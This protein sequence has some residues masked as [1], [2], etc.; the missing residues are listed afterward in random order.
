VVSISATANPGFRFSGWSG[1]LSGSTNPTSVV[2]N[3][4]KNVTANFS[5]TCI[6]SVLSDRWE[7]EYFNNKTLTG[8][9][10]M[11]R[12]DGTGMIDFEWSDSPSSGCGLGSTDF[13]VRWTKTIS[14]SSGTYRFT[15]TSDDG[16]RLYVDDQLKLDQWFDQGP[17]TYTADVL[18]SAGDHTIKMEYYQA[19]GGAKAFL[20][21]ELVGNTCTAVV[22]MDRWK[23]EYFNN[24]ALTGAPVMVRDD[25]TGMIDFE[26]SD[27]PS[28]GCGLGPEDFS[29]RWTRTV[30]LIN[31]IYRFTVIGDDGFRLYV[32]DQLVLDKWFDQ[33]AMIYNADVSLSTGNHT[34]K[35]EYYQS[36]GEAIAYL[37]C[38]LASSADCIDRIPSDR[39]KGEYFNNK[40]LSGFPVMVRDDGT[41]MIDFEWSASPG[42]DCGLGSTDFSVIWTRTVSF[43]SNTYRFTV[44]S[45]DG[46]RLYIDDQLKL[47]QWFDQG[48]TTYA[49]DVVLSAGDHTI[50][51][52]YYQA[53]G[54]AK[55]SLSWAN[56]SK[57]P[58]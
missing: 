20:S 56:R 1:D 48:T 4:S 51:M 42:S 19:G 29:V 5:Q 11:V 18:L 39:W 14:F 9:P 58:L 22:P 31:G 28:S 12:D 8:A 53:G 37:S 34:I 57:G 15:V 52:E 35:M 16:F 50:K 54:G 36:H 24:K 44:T 2:V 47:D 25:G 43:S 26:W 38:V 27:S 32:D 3:G 55:A 13:S 23:G 21:W 17:T 40:T 30:Y 7:G 49:L 6:S 33:G 45:D 46:F 10:V 41:G